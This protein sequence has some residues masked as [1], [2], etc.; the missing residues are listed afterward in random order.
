[1]YH[2]G[3][4]VGGTLHCSF[5]LATL[6]VS[7][8]TSPLTLTFR[9]SFFLDDFSA[10]AA[11][12]F[13]AASKTRYL[14]SAVKTPYPLFSQ[15]GIMAHCRVCMAAAFCPS[16]TAFMEH[17]LSIRTPSTSAADNAPARLVSRNNRVRPRCSFIR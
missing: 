5:R 14:L 17:I 2:Q 4:P 7:P 16:L 9:L 1:M 12:S 11:C 15:S 10:A 3:T 6:I 8:S 13:P